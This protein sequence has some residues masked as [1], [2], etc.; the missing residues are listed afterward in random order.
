MGKG[1][2]GGNKKSTKN[3]SNAEKKKKKLGERRP[4]DFL[5]THVVQSIKFVGP[6]LNDGD[7][8]WQT[9]KSDAE[10]V[11]TTD[12]VKLDNIKDSEICQN[13]T[14]EEKDVEL[15]PDGSENGEAVDDTSVKSQHDDSWT[16]RVK[17]QSIWQ[18]SDDE[19]WSLTCDD[20]SDDE[21]VDNIAPSLHQIRDRDKE[22]SV[23]V[24]DVGEIIK[25][26]YTLEKSSNFST[27]STTLSCVLGDDVMDC[28]II[29]RT[30][31][32]TLLRLDTM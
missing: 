19:I 17:Y 20:S 18:I 26:E 23:S 27:K 28:I 12:T 6:G 25:W 10:K 8:D 31:M 24:E 32:C 14:T 4:E 13:T 2:K 21:L 22:K 9:K 30:D 3:K 15:T 7:H 11:E 16:Q 5:T 1:N 29:S